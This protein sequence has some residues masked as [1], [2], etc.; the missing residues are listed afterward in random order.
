MRRLIVSAVLISFIV[1]LGSM[2]P[3]LRPALA[4]SQGGSSISAGALHSC[5][6][7]SGKAYCWGSNDAGALGDENT[8]D[9]TVPVAVD[10]SGVLAGKTLTQIA[11]GQSHTCALDNTGVAYC[12][13]ENDTGQ[14]GDGGV[15]GY[16]DV[17]VAVDTSG[18]LA[19]KTLIQIA[20]GSGHTCAL[21]GTGAAYCWGY[22][23]TGQ[24]G[25][26]DTASSRVPVAVDTSGVLAG[27]TLTQITTGSANTCVLDST[28]HAYCWG[29]GA[30]LGE[31]SGTWSAVPV[32]VDTSG[33]LAGKTLTRIAAGVVHACAVDSTG[34]AYCWGYNEYGQ[35]G[36]GSTTGSYVPVAVERS[37]VL[38]GKTL[39]QISAGDYDTCAL[40]STGAAYCWGANYD[41]Q[42]GNGSTA[43]SIVPVAVDASGV[44]GGKALTQ[45]STGSA[46][47]HTCAAGSTGAV[48]CWGDNQNGGLGDDSTTASDVPVL[49]GPQAPTDVTAV[50][51]DTTAAVSWKA[52][53]SLDGGTLTG[54][55]ATASPG[56]A[57]CTMT[58]VTTCTMT[59]LTDG[60]TYSIT[61]VAHT[62]AGD[63]GASAPV[64][65]TPSG[66]PTFSSGPADT[67]AY[68]VAFAF[69]VTATGFPAPEITKAGRLPSGVCFTAGKDGTATISGRPANSAA[70]VYPL[71]LTARNR[72]G[73]ATQAFTLTVTRAPAIRKI[74]T[75]RARVGAPMTLT[76]RAKGYPAPALAESGWLPGGLSFTD[77]GNGTGVIGGTPA[78][79]S[80]GRYPVTITA[81]NTSGTATRHFTI[82][83]W[84]PRRR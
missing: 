47:D 64:T 80:G 45:I 48:Y 60:T 62:T 67:V 56:A 6:I 30:E 27:K 75:T 7:E 26:G 52:P 34:A 46:G 24:L 53:G 13:G 72:T 70:G 54:Y 51:G 22:N 12:W 66:R 40:D 33:V 43:D 35:L 28:G 36:D 5:A 73:S 16:S 1:G 74:Q 81:T 83:A 42:L 79:G 29:D 77:N 63:S 18:V 44:L 9:S 39:T 61:V 23:E 38:A 82:I 58:G 37:G 78:A 15:G 59:R 8:S 49:A 68:G 32:A 2:P 11:A 76:I 31:G 19:G 71:T 50:P 17:P 3:V 25:D 10:T 84:R 55:T 69:K 65:V 20:A 41:G 21:D 4:A 14:L 57:A